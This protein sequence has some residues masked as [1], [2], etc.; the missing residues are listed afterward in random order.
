MVA[1]SRPRIKMI[2][3]QFEVT[4]CPLGKSEPKVTLVIQLSSISNDTS[5]ETLVD[6]DD[7][8]TK[9]ASSS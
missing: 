1:A 7:G 8:G 9:A 6:F 5:P 3:M 2:S 4:L